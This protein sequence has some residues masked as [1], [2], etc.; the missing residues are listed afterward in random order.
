MCAVSKTLVKVLRLVNGDKLAMG[1][2]YEAMDRDKETI[3]N[4]YVGN[5]TPRHNRHMLLWDLID[6]RWTRMLH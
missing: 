6:S 2:L 4:Y 3:Q 5:G 1:Y